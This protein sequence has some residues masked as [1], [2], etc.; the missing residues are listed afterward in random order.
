VTSVKGTV[1]CGGQRPGTSSLVLSGTGV[2]GA[3]GP[4][5]SPVRVQ[6][7]PGPTVQAT[8]IVQVGGKPA[9][10]LIA[11]RTGAFTLFTSTGGGTHFYQAPAAGVT[12]LT[13]TGAKLDGDAVEAAAAGGAPHTVH[14]AGELV[15]G[16]T[17]QF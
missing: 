2:D 16:V 4:A 11:V 10:A 1:D 5:V 7:D 13:P 14:V 6:C 3:V 8:G 12:A 9:L 15:C 17:G